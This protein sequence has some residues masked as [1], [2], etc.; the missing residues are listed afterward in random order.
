M[1][2]SSSTIK[3]IGEAKVSARLKKSCI[4][5]NNTCALE[6]AYFS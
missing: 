1:Q 2:C 5:I 6:E 4:I 3:E